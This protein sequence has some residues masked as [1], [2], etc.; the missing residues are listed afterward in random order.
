[1]KQ[2]HPLLVC[3]MAL[4][5]P[6]IIGMRGCTSLNLPP[7]PGTPVPSPHNGMFVCGADTLIFNGDG[8]TVSW[9][10]AQAIPDIGAEGQGEYVFLFGHGKC[11]YDVA[12][13]FRI[14]ATGNQNASHP[15]ML[16]RFATDSTI[17]VVRNGSKIDVFKKHR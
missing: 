6:S 13:T 14:I 4:M 8:K 15:F 10:F 11:R 2:F 1:M 16:P 17:T 3:I 7:D 5:V 12:E 9:H